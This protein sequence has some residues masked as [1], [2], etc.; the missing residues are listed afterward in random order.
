MTTETNK[1]PFWIIAA[2]LI[3]LLGSA[4]MAEPQF[5]AAEQAEID[6]FCEEFGSD[7][8]AVFA[9]NFDRETLLHKAAEQGKNWKQTSFHG[10]PTHGFACK[11][12]AIVPTKRS[13][14]TW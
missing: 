9:V 10:S 12:I 4:A 2:I 8:D 5:T 6:K 13:Y 1:K 14:E 3:L 7:I 11:R